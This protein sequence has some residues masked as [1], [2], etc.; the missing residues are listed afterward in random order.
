[1]TKATK[2]VRRETYT[3]VRERGWSRSDPPNPN[4]RHWTVYAL[5]DPRDSS[6]RYVGVTTSSLHRRLTQHISDVRR[7]SGR[8]TDW[9]KELLGAGIKPSIKPLETGDGISWIAAEKHWILHYS[10]AVLYNA[11]PGGKMPS[12]EG[13]AAI[14]RKLKGVPKT[15]EMRAKLS[16]AMKGRVLWTPEER[17]AMSAFRRSLGPASPE[18]RR[19]QSEGIKAAFKAIAESDPQRLIDRQKRAQATWRKKAKQIGAAISKGKMGHAVSAVTRERISL[20]KRAIAQAAF[21]RD[22]QSLLVAIQ[23]GKLSVS[24]LNTVYCHEDKS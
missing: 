17:A 3:S 13:R 11:S 18:T 7:L 4:D 21:N 20:T 8:K 12:L 2:P 6:V 1:M 23:S 9:L 16:A 10:S 5:I 15:P 19:R 14:S 24:S 22:A